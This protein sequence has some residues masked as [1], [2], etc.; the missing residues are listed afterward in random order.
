MP[1]NRRTQQEKGLLAQQW[2]TPIDEKKQIEQ[3]KYQVELLAQQWATPIDGPTA[4][5]ELLLSFA[6]LSKQAMATVSDGERNGMRAGQSQEKLATARSE[7]IHLHD[8]G[9]PTRSE[10][11][12][13]KS[14]LFDRGGNELAE[15]C[16]PANEQPRRVMPPVVVPQLPPLTTPHEVDIPPLPIAAATVKLGARAEMVIEDDLDM[17]AARIKRILDD[18][19][20]RHGIDV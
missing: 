9:E 15:E 18:E 20:R 16:P 13:W 4:P 19:A 3:R 14:P 7:S 10:D 1:A 12:H 6:H 5:L 8:T 2:A 11:N 17:L